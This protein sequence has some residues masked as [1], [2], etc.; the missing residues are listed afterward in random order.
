MPPRVRWRFSRPPQGPPF[1]AVGF[2]EACGTSPRPGLCPK[3]L[4]I[5]SP[6]PAGF[7]E[8]CGNSPRPGRSPKLCSTL[9]LGPGGRR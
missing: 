4:S 3:L 9:G 5:W 7:A 6:G 8:A 2:A 1:R